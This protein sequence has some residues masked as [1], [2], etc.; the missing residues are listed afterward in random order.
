MAIEEALVFQRPVGPGE[1][2]CPLRDPAALREQVAWDYSEDYLE[3]VGKDAESMQN[4]K[5]E[6]L[7]KVARAV[8]DHGHAAPA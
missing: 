5:R 4:K 7:R 6:S 3:K 1:D 8:R 2:R